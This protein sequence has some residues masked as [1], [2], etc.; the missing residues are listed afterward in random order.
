M[1]PEIAE[2]MQDGENYLVNHDGFIFEAYVNKYDSE[3]YF[4]CDWN[5]DVESAS[6]M[7]LKVHNVP[8]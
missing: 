7:R 3:F 1:T 4:S 2:Q 5:D 6:M 8:V